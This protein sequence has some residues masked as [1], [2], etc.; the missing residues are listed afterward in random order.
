[1]NIP[2][3]KASQTLFKS[4]ESSTRRRPKDT[5]YLLSNPA[6]AA[7][8]FD[9]FEQAKNQEFVSVKFDNNAK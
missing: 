5:E 9:S 7:R 8:L 4:R 2:T 1:M 6:N 3:K